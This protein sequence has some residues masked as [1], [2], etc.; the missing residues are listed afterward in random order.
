MLSL[1]DKRW[2]ELLGG[3]KVQ[4]DPRPALARLETGTNA[5]KAWHELWEE[6]HHQGDV[7]QASYAAVPH[8]VRIHRKRRLDPWNVYAMVA[9]I[10]L[11]RGECGNPEVPRWLETDY[12]KALQ[13]LAKSASAEVLQTKSAKE[14]RAMLSIIALAKG[15]KAHA[16]LPPKLF[17]RRTHRIRESRT[18]RGAMSPIRGIC[19]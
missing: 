7:G 2:G 6:L 11:A 18:Q 5:K 13:E 12:F 8:W 19:A 3:Y 17:Q 14:A 16:R 10:E 9:I 1:T 4:F 15:A